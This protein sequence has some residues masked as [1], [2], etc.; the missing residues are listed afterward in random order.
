MRPSRLLADLVRKIQES[1]NPVAI[2]RGARHFV[3]TYIKSLMGMSENM[4]CSLVHNPK[5]VPEAS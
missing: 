5:C 4:K 2:F 1:A 3:H